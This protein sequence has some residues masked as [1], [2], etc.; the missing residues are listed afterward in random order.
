M[1]KRIL[2]YFS[3]VSER[4]STGKWGEKYAC[5]YLRRKGLEVLKR[6]FSCKTGEIDLIMTEADGSIV[7]VEVRTRESKNFAPPEDTV[8]KNKQ[9][10]I[11]RA[12][13]YFLNK[14][15]IKD[16]PLR[17]DVVAITAGNNKRKPEVRHYKNAF[18]E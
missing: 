5:K 14:Y 2:N 3:S 16:R 6:N 8:N 9:K 17:F 11:I 10:K 15:D 13:R 12:A 18:C 4:K 7:F 1:I